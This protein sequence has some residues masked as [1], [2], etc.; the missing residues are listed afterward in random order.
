MLMTPGFRR[1]MMRV[2]STLATVSTLVICT[3]SA[4]AQTGCITGLV[5]DEAGC[6]QEHINVEARG[7]WTHYQTWTNSNG[8]FQIQGVPPAKYGIISGEADGP[9]PNYANSFFYGTADLLLSVAASG[10]CEHVVVHLGP[11]TARLN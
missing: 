1:L 7:T 6:P 11:A 5:I 3:A 2:L 9:Y 4:V 10:Q 8:E